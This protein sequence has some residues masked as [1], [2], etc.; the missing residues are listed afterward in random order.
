MAGRAATPRN[1]REAESL[2]TAAAPI[3]EKIIATAIFVVLTTKK[4]ILKDIFERPAVIAINSAKPGIGL[5]IIKPIILKFFKDASTSSKS[6]LLIIFLTIGLPAKRPNI[7]ARVAPK[8]RPIQ[9]TIDEI[10]QP[11]D[12]PARVLVSPFGTG[13]ITSA[14][15]AKITNREMDN[16][17]DPAQ[18]RAKFP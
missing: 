11:N 2:S 5:E 4:K 10:A 9:I 8:V 18:L 3:P 1:A 7:Y 16:L 12:I 17:L 14:V 6:L 15:K 13:K